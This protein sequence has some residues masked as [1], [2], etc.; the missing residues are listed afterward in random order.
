MKISIFTMATVLS[1][2][3]SQPP[4]RAGQTDMGVAMPDKTSTAATEYRIVQKDANSRVWQRETY[5][6]T[7]GGALSRHIHQYT[8]LETGLYHR[9]ALGELVESSEEIVL[10]PDGSAAATNGQHQVYFPENIYDG[11]IMVE[12]PTGERIQSR[13]ILLCYVDGTNSVVLA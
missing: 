7:P 12:T 2:C 9:D 5:E 1:L 4:I 6:K 3:A 11:S 13:P 8:E 10:L